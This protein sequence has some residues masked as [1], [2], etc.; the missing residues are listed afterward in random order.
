MN[1]KTMLTGVID[2]GAS[3][4]GSPDLVR[5]VVDGIADLRRHADR[6]IEVL[7]QEVEVHIGVAEGSV[8]VIER[9]VADPMFDREVEAGLRNRLVRMPQ[10][11]MPVR[12]Y[13]VQA[14]KRTKIEVKEIEPR[15]YQLRIEGGDRDGTSFVLPP[16]RRDLLIGRG[17]W[18]GD[19][20]QVANDVIVSNEER[21]ISRRAARLHRMGAAFELESVDQRESLTIR[22]AD[23]DRLRPALSASGRV[24]LKPGDVVEFTD[25]ATPVLTMRLEEA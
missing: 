25:G 17:P 1:I 14:A 6:G 9:F 24:P 21:R 15:K 20:Q 22:K 19:D 2:G 16:G 7:P 4:L 5:R 10:E 8:K 12:H 3:E 13:Q 11:T 23:G 18:H